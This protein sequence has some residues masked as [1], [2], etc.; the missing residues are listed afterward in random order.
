MNEWGV[1]LDLLFVK[2]FAMISLEFGKSGSCL[3]VIL[4]EKYACDEFP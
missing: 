4:A 2:L 3:A 1:V